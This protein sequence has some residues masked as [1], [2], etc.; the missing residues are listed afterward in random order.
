MNEPLL[1]SQ[2]VS[3]TIGGREILAGVSL[4]VMPGEVL[5]LIGPNGAGKS[6]LLSLLAGDRFPDSGS[7]LLFGEPLQTIPVKERARRRSVL[8]QKPGV[9]FAFRVRE[10]V[11]MGRSPWRGTPESSADAEIVAES[12]EAVEVEHLE[13]RDVLN[14]SGGES[15]RVSIARVLAQRTPVVLLDEPAA[16][17]D[18]RHQEHVMSL[19][20]ELA[21]AG[22]GVVVVSHD[23]DAAAHWSDRVVLLQQGRVRATGE[24]SEV[25][26][27][28]LLSD[29]YDTPIEVFRHPVTGAPVVRPVRR[30]PAES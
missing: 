2:D 5:S 26:T 1:Q 9:G 22:S 27:S 17:L 21:A 4:Q 24:P 29:V 7:V 11:A 10:V 25:L 14:L 28:E 30:S 19:A 13:Q 15:S 20:R 23:L 12:I 18:V 3:L 6:T 16:A 8:E